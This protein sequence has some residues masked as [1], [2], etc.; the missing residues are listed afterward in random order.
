VTGMLPKRPPV[1]LDSD[2]YKRLCQQVMKR[3]GWTCQ[4]C[5]SSQNLQVHH[6]TFRS[7]QGSD[8]DSNLITLCAGCHKKRHSGGQEWGLKKIERNRF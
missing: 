1:R 3:D 5:S 4:V 6:K 2:S 7:Q 8:E